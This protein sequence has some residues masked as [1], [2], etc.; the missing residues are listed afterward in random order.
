MSHHF[1]TSADIPVDGERIS[2]SKL[3]NIKR[4]SGGVAAI[5]GLLSA[6]LLFGAPD[7]IAGPFAY[8]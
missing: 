3:D 7:K 1:V 2:S 5:T 6:Y 4:V 8:S